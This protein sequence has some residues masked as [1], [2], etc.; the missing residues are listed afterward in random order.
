MFNKDIINAENLFEKLNYGKIFCEEGFYYFNP[1]NDKKVLFDL[2][3]KKC[4]VYDYVTLEMRNYGNELLKAIL[5]QEL[6]L[7][8]ITYKEYKLKLENI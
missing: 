2:K 4:F 7:N 8:W 6:E 3:N 5:L 1:K